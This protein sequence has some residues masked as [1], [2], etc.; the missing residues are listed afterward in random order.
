MR[1]PRVFTIP[2]GTPFLPTLAD[3]LLDGRLTG[4]W[5]EGAELPDATLYLPT[6]RA[7]RALAALLAER[8][9]RRAVLLPRIVP[10]GDADEDLFE[11]GRDGPPPI[12]SGERRLILARLVQRWM[13][14]FDRAAAGAGQAF[15]P[16][17]SAADAVAL[18]SDLA[19]LMDSLATEGIAWDELAGAVEA[20]YSDYFAQTLA[21]V[22][23]AHE[24]W[25][26]ILAE[27]GASDPARRRHDALLAEA[28]RL[29][30]DPPA[31]PVVA[32]GSTGSVPATAQLL[33]AIARLPHGAVV[34]PGLDTGLD[35]AAW[36]AIGGRDGARDLEAGPLWGHPQCMMRRLL[37]GALDVP[38]PD[39]VALGP[40]LA[41]HHPV[42]ARRRL[43]SEV[44]RPA[45]STDAWAAIPDLERRAIAEAGCEGLALIEAGDEREEALA[46]AIA[47]REVLEEP[48]RTAALVT[49]DRALARRVAIELQRW[50]VAVEDSA[51][52]SL[53][54]TPAGH[55]ARLAAEAV[56]ARFAPLPVLALLAHPAVTLG[57]PR[58][59]IERAA[60]SLEIAVLRGPAPA[61]GL[62]GIAAGLRLRRAKR[63]HRDPLPRRRLCESDWNEAEDLVMRLERAFADFGSVEAETRADL[64]EHAPRH[65][66]AILALIEPATHAHL[67][68]PLWG[69]AGGGGRDARGELDAS[70]TPPIRPSASLGTTFPAGG[71]EAPGLTAGDMNAVALQGRVSHAAQSPELDPSFGPLFALLDELALMPPSAAVEGRLT[72]YP[73]FFTAIARERVLAPAS[74]S[75]HRRVTILGLLEARLLEVDRIVL[76]TLDESIWPPSAESDPFLNRPMRLKL[77]L[78]PPE[79]R[80]GQTAH[81]FVQALG[82]PDAI[83]TRARKREGKPTV[84]SRFLERLRSFVGAGPWAALEE[85]GARY[86]ALG[87][88]L[89]APRS[90]APASRPSP[91]PGPER[92][93]RRLSVTEI[94]T[95]VRDPYAIFARHILRL[96]PL[97]EVGM[98]PSLA[99]RG[100]ILHEVLAQFAAAHPGELPPGAEA[101]LL[102]RGAD[103]FRGLADAYPELHA[104]WWPD[105]QRLVPHLL[106]WEGRRRARYGIRHLERS[107]ELPIPLDA[108]ALIVRGTADR[109]EIG[110]DGTASIVDFKTGTVP[111]DKMMAAGFSPQLTLEAAMLRAGGFRDVPAVAGTPAL[112]YVKLG[113]RQRLVDRELRPPKDAPSMGELVDKHVEGLTGLARRY[114]VEGAGYVSRPYP[115]Y[116]LAYSDYDHLARV[117]EWSLAE[118]GEP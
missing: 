70:R 39:V 95:L 114:G 73:A 33:A 80:I 86:L 62:S 94:E 64:V 118:G 89:D 111:T 57:L 29:L 112:H 4:G 34:L 48:G 22:R 90:V 93:P 16:A 102:Q 72:E 83:L 41:P 25:P 69:G 26:A 2:P 1:D 84:P 51:G 9:E 15:V 32:A 11:P 7:G 88:A 18:A 8:S 3:A 52:T 13:E 66:A 17:G 109:I 82:T 63:N 98:L 23:I 40:D 38:R 108:D 61:S 85:G 68:S 96:A 10:L 50:G 74:G 117:A 71:K 106:A 105:F 14:A 44:M 6:R 45:E 12:P 99:E 35:E 30:A 24:A 116:A 56:A 77:G 103:A 31:G 58:A 27:R 53:A 100:T 110:E 65:L 43:L 37:A 67:P 91:R 78:S 76:A 75:G 42:A 79:R 115:Q 113:G 28:A 81:D 97:D 49:P 21:F 92:F 104:L 19:A 46:I 107:G 54:D 47:L 55:L 59:A 20:E 5:P 60:S 36:T 101:E 87:R